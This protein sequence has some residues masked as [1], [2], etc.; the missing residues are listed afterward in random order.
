[1]SDGVSATIAPA[2]R[3]A[4][5]FSDAVPI[6][7]EMMAPACPMRLPGGAVVPAMKA[8]TGFVIDDA[9]QAAASSS[10]EPPISPIMMTPS[11]A[12]SASNIAS[13]STNDVPFTGSP[14]M[15]IAVVCPRP[16]SVSCFTAS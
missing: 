10:A 9:I 3:R 2:S 7:P 12:G 8:A 16:T 1:M 6:P 15:P 5:I 11:V 14:P 4:A 13:A